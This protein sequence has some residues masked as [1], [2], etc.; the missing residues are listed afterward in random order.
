MK[1]INIY[2][3]G[4]CLGN[5]GPGGWGTI[6]QYGKKEKVLSG[7]DTQTT[8]NRM[9]MQAV[10]EGLKWVKE[11][12]MED[13]K[14]AVFSDSSLVVK[15]M[16]EGWKRKTN[17]D[18]WAEVDAAVEGLSVEWNWVKGHAGHVQNERCDQLAVA[19]AEK[20]QRKGGSS[21]NESSKKSSGEKDGVFTCGA[22]GASTEGKLGYMTASRMIRVDCP[23]CGRYIKFA[24]PTR[25]NLKRA[26]ERPLITK[27]QLAMMKKREEDK[28]KKVSDLELKRWKAM[29]Q[30]EAYFL[31]E[32][33]QTLF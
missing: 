29:T 1:K 3:D 20:I 11:N 24:S 19:E 9:E 33:E 25:E 27:K 14:V 23:N 2:T 28:G 6:I 4:S 22:C 8:N 18:V 16:K 7:G 30:K 15:T 12:G 32:S 10:A 17:Q 21:T 13:E 26:K 5:P 31:L